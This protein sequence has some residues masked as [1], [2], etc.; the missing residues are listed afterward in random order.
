[1]AGQVLNRRLSFRDRG[2]G[3]TITK[4]RPLLVQQLMTLSDSKKEQRLAPV[5]LRTSR[6]KMEVNMCKSKEVQ[7][8]IELTNH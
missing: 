6:R 7:P 1:M 3:S 8:T 5:E 4:R 2:Q